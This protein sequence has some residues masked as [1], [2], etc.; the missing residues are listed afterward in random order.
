[1]KYVCRCTNTHNNVH[2]SKISYLQAVLSKV[3]DNG[4]KKVNQL[5]SVISNMDIL[6]L[7]AHRVL[8]LAVVKS[9]LEHGSDV[10][11]AN[12]AQVA[13]LESVVLRG[14]LDCSLGTCNEVVYFT[15]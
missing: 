8:L 11:E 5:H 2:L 3:L 1:M 12:K 10:W 4:R 13:A 9:T 15:L 7:S 6:N 14:A